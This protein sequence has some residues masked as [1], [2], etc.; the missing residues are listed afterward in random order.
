MLPRNKEQAIATHARLKEGVG[1]MQATVASL[2]ESG[3]YSMAAIRCD[4]LKAQLDE[5]NKV[6]NHMADR[7]FF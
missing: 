4:N 3:D 7:D 2:I 1:A 5:L 6:E